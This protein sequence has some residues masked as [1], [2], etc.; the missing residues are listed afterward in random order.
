MIFQQTHSL[1][2]S[3]RKGE[4]S[5][6]STQVFGM[7]QISKESSAVHAIIHGCPSSWLFFSQSHRQQAHSFQP[8]GCV[9]VS[10]VETGCDVNVGRSA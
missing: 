8:K 2:R 1:Q 10:E 4:F 7:H 5:C 3:E 6:Y 9:E